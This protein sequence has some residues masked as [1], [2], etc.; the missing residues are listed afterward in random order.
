MHSSPSLLKRVVVTGALVAAA[1]G[2]RLWPFQELGTSIPFLTFYPAVIAAALYG[3]LLGGVLATVLTST[4]IYAWQPTGLSFL[5]SPAE[6]LGLAFFII[7]GIV[8]ASMTEAM[9]RARERLAERE[10]TFRTLAGN[11]PDNISR[12]DLACRALYLNPTLE[13]TLGR[14]AEELLGKPI[15]ESFPDGR[16]AEL[17]K[18]IL[19]VGATGHAMEVEQIVPGEN[20][21]DRYHSIRLVA[22]LGPDEKPVSVLGV[23]RDLTRQKKAEEE[24]RLAASVFHNSSEGVLV[25]DAHGTILSVNPAF[26]KITGYDAEAAVGQTPRLLRSEHHVPSFYQAMSASLARDGY[27]QGEIWNRHKYGQVYLVWLTIDCIRDCVGTPVR[28]V[29]VFHDITELRR[30]EEQIR[31]LAFHDPLTDLPNRA[32]LQDRLV[33][34]M[35]RAKRDAGRF[36]LTFIDLDRFKVINDELGHDVG[37]LL[38]R[39]VASRIKGRLRTTDTVARMGGDEFVVLMEG[40]TDT[41]ECVHVAAEL[42]AEVSRPMELRGRVLQ[43]G[44]SMGI[45]FFPEDGEDATELMKHADMAM[46]A[47]KSAGRGRYR[48][49]GEGLAE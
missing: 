31:H 47:A 27:W 6:Y 34:A 42:V 11:V 21:V 4:L 18:A 26:G 20:G 2:L 48:F 15:H 38:L 25:T 13:Q 41:A 46:Y 22:E 8:V 17:E 30:K 33:Q 49:F 24:L 7:N 43:I 36:S 28:Y 44:A 19:H 40:L 5:Q 37:D 32:L 14:P 45:A 16:F 23:G 3:G 10:S 12:H 35:A 9:H 29:G 1:G 39:E